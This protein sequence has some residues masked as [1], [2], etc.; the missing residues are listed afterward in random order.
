MKDRYDNFAP[1][2]PLNRNTELFMKKKREV[3]VSSSLPT[4]AGLSRES[5]SWCGHFLTKAQF[6]YLKERSGAIT[7][8]ST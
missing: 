7:V 2:Q 3:N 6:I 4:A 5:V 1:F 8:L